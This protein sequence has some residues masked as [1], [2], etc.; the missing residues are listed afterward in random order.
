MA[1]KGKR[2]PK[3]RAVT[4]GPKPV[5]VPPKRPL[6]AR[7]GFWL[8]V[9]IVVLAGAAAGVITG[10]MIKRSNDHREAERA[11]V[12]RFG[13]SVDTSLQTVGQPIGSTFQAFPT[14]SQTIGGL[15]KGTT[16]AADA[17]KSAKSVKK[18]ALNAYEQLQAI[19]VASMTAGHSDLGGI[20]DAQF[21]LSD[22]LQV[23]Q[24]V[25]E[26][27]ALAAGVRGKER[28]RLV[29]QAEDLLAVAQSEIAHGYGKLSA[30]R[31][32]FGLA[33]AAPPPAPLPTGVVS[34]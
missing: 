20:G 8:M 32:Q 33:S 31:S 26:S 2:K 27:I 23:Y 7:R 5:Y 17:A 21:E 14:L 30:L 34:P 3:R 1:I 16:K 13:R 29:T 4:T 9:G 18:Q 6:F 24:Q 22:A 19:P 15:K 12:A 25:G 28:D 10:F 11:I